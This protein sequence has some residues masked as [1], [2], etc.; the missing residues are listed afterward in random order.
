MFF[1]YQGEREMANDNKFLGSLELSDL[2]P[3]PRGQL[4]IK[5]KLEIDEQGMVSVSHYEKDVEDPVK[6]SLVRGFFS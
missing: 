5:V 1:S 6:G 3:M 2:P 4:K